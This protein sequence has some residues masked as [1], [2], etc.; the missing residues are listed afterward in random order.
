MPSV[1]PTNRKDV[2]VVAGMHRSGT[3]AVARVLSLAGGRLPERV[4]EPGPDNPLGFW[5]PHEMVALNDELLASVGSRWDDVF[6]HRV[7]A[8]VQAHPEQFR[9]EA[10]EFIAGNYG[11]LDLAVLKDPRASLAIPFWDAALRDAGGEPVYIIM[12]RH[13]LEV[14]RSI[15]A[16]SGAAEANSALAWAA[17]MLSVERDTRTARRIFIDYASLLA[18]WRGVMDRIEALLGRRLPKRSA[19]AEAEIDSFLHGGMRHHEAESAELSRRTD[20]WSEIAPIYDWLRAAA[21]GQAQD[22]GPMDHACRELETLASATDPALKDLRAEAAAFPAVRAELKEAKAEI[23]ALRTLANQFHAEADHNGRHLK[24]AQD[25]I[26]HI[27]H[28]LN[29]ARAE[30]GTAHH[31]ATQLLPVR[32]EIALVEAALLRQTTRN[33]ELD[34]ALDKERRLAVAHT[35]HAKNEQARFEADISRLSTRLADASDAAIG[36]WRAREAELSDQIATLSDEIR[37]AQALATSAVARG[38]TLEDQNRQLAAANDRIVNST[39]WRWSRPL[40]VI[41]KRLKALAVGTGPA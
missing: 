18:D 38:E 9:S 14:A 32:R 7:A 36:Q 25:Q 37:A 33:K 1:K 19:E 10:R 15:A 29:L 12:V 27:S 21:E 24:A 5:E 39:S 2:L 34:E 23:E 31:E 22:P 13:P 6:G 8:A 17:Y 40:R 3:S 26:A 4:M 41:V 16:R 35:A 20:L 28:Q 11:E 30:A